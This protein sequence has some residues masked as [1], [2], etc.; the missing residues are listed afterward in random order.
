MSNLFRDNLYNE[1]PDPNKKIDEVGEQLDN[2]FGMLS[3]SQ[4]GVSCKSLGMVPDD[5]NK[6]LSN[7]TILLNAVKQGSKILVDGTYYVQSP[8]TVADTNNQVTADI[9]IVGN[10]KAKSKLISL[11]GRFFNAKGKVLVESITIDCASTTSLTYF[12]SLVAPYRTEIT[13]K[14]NYVKGNV[15]MVD[16]SIPINYD[17]VAND[18]GISKLT[19]EDNEFY[20]VYNSTGSRYIFKLNDTPITI[21]YLRDNKVTNFSYVFFYNGISNGNTSTNYIYNSCKKFYIT[22]NIVI[23]EDSYDPTVKNGGFQGGYFCFC[24]T[25]AYTTECKNNT[26]EGFHIFDAPNTVVYDNYFSV[27]ELIY[28]NN[29]WKNIVNF[30]ADIQYVDIMKSKM[31][32]STDALTRTYRKNTYIVEP[33]Y[34]DRFS[35]DRFMLRKQIDTY[36]E[37]MDKVIIEDNL[38]DMYTLSFNR[39][40]Y[41]KEYIFNK[42]TV[43]TYTIE[44]SKN[45]Q[46]LIGIVEYKDS[47]GNLVP[48]QLIFSNNTFV[49][50]NPPVGGAIGTLEYSLIRN[51][52]G[53]GD[54]ITVIFENNYIKTYELKYIL[55]DERTDALT[56]TDPC[57][58]NIKFNGNTVINS[59]GTDTYIMSKKFKRI[60]NFK[61]NEI[62]T[63][64]TDNQKSLFVFY[65]QSTVDPATRFSLP[66]C[67]DLELDFKYKAGA[68][69]KLLPLK[70]LL[71]G[72]YKVSMNVKLLSMAT[73]EEFDVNFTVRNNG[74]SNIIDCTGLDNK[75]GESQYT[76]KS[77]VLDGSAAQTYSNFYIQQENFKGISTLNVNVSNSATGREVMLQSKSPRAAFDEDK[78]KIRMTITKV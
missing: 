78:V 14:N 29:T 18:C 56:T 72:N 6:A 30:T 16:S 67:L 1:F 32:S 54:K 63:L 40:R 20:D 47:G 43:R 75:A 74:T 68:W 25:E 15:R 27:T 49:A 21:T 71:D 33:S 12:V 58:A 73:F 44:N 24:L 17:F 42:N 3:S 60:Y 19:I 8:Y 52:S 11:G 64:V 70:G 77:Y 46:G 37:W 76:A 51:Y 35:K 57:V 2:K 55:A 7:Y 62:E 53:N 39:F 31:G 69:L 28:E 10:N 23:N 9:S 13:L 45:T 61:N 38:F 4:P 26:F 50:Q 5:S 36:Q 66:V 34:A 41:T 48:R 65:E 22:G 59:R